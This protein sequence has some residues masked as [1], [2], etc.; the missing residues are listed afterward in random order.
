MHET[1]HFHYCNVFGK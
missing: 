1:F